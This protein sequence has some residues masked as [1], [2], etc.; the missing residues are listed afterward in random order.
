MLYRR[1]WHTRSQNKPVSL[2]RTFTKM[3][4][5]ALPGQQRPG[6][7]KPCCQ[8]HVGQV[9]CFGSL[10]AQPQPNGHIWTV[11]CGACFIALDTTLVSRPII[12]ISAVR[13]APCHARDERPRNPRSSDRSCHSMP[14]KLHSGERA[15]PARLQ[16]SKSRELPAPRC[17]RAVSVLSRPQAQRA[18]HIAG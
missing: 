2:S 14:P 6:A 9:Q 16:S 1:Q 8:R 18:V 5:L 17:T 15:S 12:Q 11:L 7:Q 10:V 4:V 3:S 13:L